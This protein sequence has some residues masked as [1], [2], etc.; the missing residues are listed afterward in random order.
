[1]AHDFRGQ[2]VAV[3]GGGDNAF[4]N[5]LYAMNRGAASATIFARTVRAQHQL[6]ARVPVCDVH[7]GGY[8][9]DVERMTVDGRPFDLIMVFY[10]WEPCVPFARSL[11]LELTGTGFVAVDPLTTQTSHDKV[12]AIGEVSQRQHPCVVTAMADGVVAAK[13]IQ[14]RVESAVAGSRV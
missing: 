2:K 6:V 7:E 5:A 4:E 9:V 8:A 13:A 14:A 12:Y 10:G 3:L 11:R 1:M